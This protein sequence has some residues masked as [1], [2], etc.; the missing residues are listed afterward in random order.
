MYL[1]LY[2]VAF[3]FELRTKLTF[4]NMW[5]VVLSTLRGW[6][7]TWGSV[8]FFFLPVVMYKLF[9]PQESGNKAGS[10]VW[11]HILIT[12][13]YPWCALWFW[14][15]AVT[16]IQFCGPQWRENLRQFVTGKPWRE[17]DCQVSL[18]K[19]FPACYFKYFSIVC[20]DCYL[21]IWSRIKVEMLCIAIKKN[22][23]VSEWVV[24]RNFKIRLSCFL[25]WAVLRI[26][27]WGVRWP[28]TQGLCCWWLLCFLF[29][30][31]PL[32]RRLLIVRMICTCRHLKPVPNAVRFS[33]SE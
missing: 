2:P 22:V 18:G 17:R 10:I 3:L 27:A 11:M 26:M 32:C 31:H 4:R 20:S 9:Y 19:F 6:L 8:F 7:S 25:K 5:L 21:P 1:K 28:G 13:Y 33:F 15:A 29:F 24:L 16:S 23:I 12:T 30:A 14:H